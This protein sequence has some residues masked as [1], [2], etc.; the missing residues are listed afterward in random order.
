VSV[1][2]SNL[3]FR[4]GRSDKVYNIQVEASGS[5]YMVNYQYGR[6]G[7]ALRSA[8]FTK[9][10]VSH[11]D[12]KEMYEAK[13]NEK[14][15]EGYV[16]SIS[17]ANSVNSAP[18][19]MEGS[20]RASGLSPMLLNAIDT[21]RLMQLM[22]DDNWLMQEKLDGRRQFVTRV[23]DTIGSGNRRG[24]TVPVE[25]SVAEAVRS[26]KTKKPA[27]FALDGEL[28]GEGQFAPFD[29][30]RY[31]GVDLASQ[32]IE[33][34]LLILDGLIETTN[35]ASIKKVRTA[36]T[37]SEKFALFESIF[38]AGGEGVVF[39]KLG[40]KYVPGRPNSGGNA[41][42]YKFLGSATCIV[43]G[44]NGNKASVGIAVRDGENWIEVGH[45]TIPPNHK[46]PMA[47]MLV[48]VEYMNLMRGGS[49]YQAVYKGERDDKTEADAYDSLRFKGEAP[50]APVVEAAPAVEETP[51]QEEMV[52]VEVPVTPAEIE[53][54]AVQAEAPL[55]AG[56]KAAQTRKLRAAG[57]VP[58]AAP[59]APKSEGELS[60][61][62]KAWI[63]RKAKTANAA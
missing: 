56:Q 51:A 40:T 3:S 38:N 19:E 59:K 52:I 12:A 8:T 6:R 57:I 45:V 30:V 37:A 24:L 15:T 60:P 21:P 27:D 50:K 35:S 17:P 49:L 13:V 39:K 18:V 9:E 29:I 14:V 63:T 47:G 55:T 1:L 2:S 20:G 62:Q 34:R 10:P 48:E 23:G 36:Y 16:G 22:Q 58:P 46:M 26:L 28:L 44:Q 53:V 61:A 7:S 11:Y 31:A 32:P 4:D 42:K 25:A 41:L 54:P 5:G 33:K 43:T